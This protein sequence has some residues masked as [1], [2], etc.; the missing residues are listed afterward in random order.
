MLLINVHMQSGNNKFIFILEFLDSRV[1]CLF[2]LGQAA[3]P[4]SLRRERLQGIGWRF[5]CIMCTHVEWLLQTDA[6]HFDFFSRI[7]L[8]LFYL[9]FVWL[10]CV[11][12]FLFF[13]FTEN[14]KTSKYGINGND[15]KSVACSIQNGTK[16]ISCGKDKVAWLYKNGSCCK[17][18]VECC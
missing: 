9:W 5:L 15:V 18:V 3:W 12:L 11:S 2:W 13:D 8:I 10:H 17:E 1:F 6:L 7:G 14:T 4:A 16:Q